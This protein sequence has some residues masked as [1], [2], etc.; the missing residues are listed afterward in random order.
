MFPPLSDTTVSVYYARFSWATSSAALFSRSCTI[1]VWPCR[2]ARCSGVSLE[3]FVVASIETPFLRSSFTILV[4]PVCAAR[5][6]GVLWNEFGAS[7]EAPF[8]R[9]TS[10]TLVWP[11][12]AARC[13]GVLLSRHLSREVAPPY[14]YGHSVK[15]DAVEY[16]CM[17]PWLQ[18]RHLSREVAPPY[19]YDHSVRQDVMGYCYIHL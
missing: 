9:S 18:S 17:C 10:T 7:V 13:S 6:N 15:Q 8:P 1:L 5:C 4:W 19:Y 12:C 3:Y 14:Y 2:A 11:F 16:C